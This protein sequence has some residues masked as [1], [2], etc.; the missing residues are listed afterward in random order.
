MLNFISFLMN[1]LQ[2]IRKEHSKKQC[3]LIVDW[4]GDD[5]KRF[6]QL[7]NLFLNGEELIKQRAA[8]PLSN[9]VQ[10]NPVLIN[11]HINELIKNLENKSH[12]NAIKRNTIRLLQYCEIPVK[13][14][15]IVIDVCFR[16]INSPTEPPAVKA[17]SLTVLEKLAQQYP[18]IF[19]ELKWVI[20]SRWSVET[21]AFKARAKKILKKYDALQKN[22]KSKTKSGVKR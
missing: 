7:F 4:I 13:Y 9:C 3:Q 17:F 2:E 22:E 12:H 21:A 10:K 8:W 5:P 6:A 19:I 1:L 20:E 11:A 14:Q 18:D 15:G 16:Y